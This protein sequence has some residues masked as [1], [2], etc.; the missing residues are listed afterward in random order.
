MV[1]V[2]NGGSGYQGGWHCWKIVSGARGGLGTHHTEGS[3]ARIEGSK[4]P[5]AASTKGGKAQLCG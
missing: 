4:P 2:V 1:A 3:A 5:F